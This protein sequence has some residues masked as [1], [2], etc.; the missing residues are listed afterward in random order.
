M[1]L[2]HIE[3]SLC[4]LYTLHQCTLYMLTIQNRT[5]HKRTDIL[6]IFQKGW[7]A[8]IDGRKSIFITR[9]D[10]NDVGIIERDTQSKFT[11]IITINSNFRNGN[12]KSQQQKQVVESEIKMNLN[13]DSTFRIES[14]VYGK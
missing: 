4:T 5:E 3:I 7:R 6:C 12:H 14:L 2:L 13:K 1:L 8:P 10:L 11:A 9:L